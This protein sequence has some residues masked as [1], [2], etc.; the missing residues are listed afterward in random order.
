MQA[1]CFLLPIHAN[2]WS[3]SMLDKSTT[4]PNSQQN[5]DDIKNLATRKRNITSLSVTTTLNEHDAV[6][7]FASVARYW[8]ELVPTISRKTFHIEKYLLLNRLTYER[9]CCHLQM[10]EFVTWSLV[11]HSYHFRLCSNE[12][13]K[14]INTLC[15][16][17]LDLY[18][19]QRWCTKT[20]FY[21]LNQIYAI[22]ID[23]T[24]LPQQA[25]CSRWYLRDKTWKLDPK[26]IDETLAISNKQLDSKK[27][28]N[29]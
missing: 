9:M 1:Y 2:C 19:S 16:S 21:F 28:I 29:R 26:K 3:K 18:K 25:L 12:L 10:Q 8:T 11:H 27:N 6:R 23:E 4:V 15:Y 20:G 5:N 24:F 17:Y 22:S 7:L 14:L 13:I